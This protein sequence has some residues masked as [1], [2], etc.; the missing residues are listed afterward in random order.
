MGSQAMR[1]EAS[2]PLEALRMQIVQLAQQASVE[3]NVHDVKYLAASRDLLARGTRIYVSHLPKQSFNDTLAACVAVR[4]MGL[5]PV[6]HV[7]VRLLRSQE[8]LYELIDNALSREV[9]KILLISGDYPEAR[10]P[11]SKVADVLRDV[12][13]RSRG[14]ERVSLGGHPEGHAKVPLHEI[15]S[16]ELEKAQIAR[17]AGL[18]ATFVTQ[19]FFEADPFLRWAKELNNAGVTAAIRAGL[20]GPAHIATLLKFAVRC[21]VGPSIRA[22]GARP[23][24]FAKLIGE[25]GPE[26]LL[27]HLAQDAITT[28]PVFHGIHIFCFGGY[29]KTCQ[30]LHSLASGWFELTDDG[31]LNVY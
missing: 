26:H 30:W 12:D 2:S 31:S 21:G 25:H 13:L 6:P 17:Q 4:T 9:K 23:S 28:P 24:A 18:D 14:L 5:E 10:G 19:F 16:A 29:L 7:P 20:A 1:D 27:R 11:Y 22:L 3:L 15:R 8:E